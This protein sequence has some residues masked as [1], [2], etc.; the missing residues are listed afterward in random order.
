MSPLFTEAVVADAAPDTRAAVLARLHGELSQAEIAAE[1]GIS[2]QRVS[3]IVHELGA[4]DWYTAARRA[5]LQGQRVRR[6]T[7]RRRA[8]EA[9]Y[10][11]CHACGRLLKGKPPKPDG[12]PSFCSRRGACNAARI[13]HYRAQKR[14]HAP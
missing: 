14:G 3:A 13:R 8:L 6:R 5:F 4:S 9:A 12:A 2:K 11:R 10:A 1:L 7:A